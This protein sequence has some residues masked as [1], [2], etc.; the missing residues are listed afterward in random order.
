ME[1]AAGS[2][3]RLLLGLI[4]FLAV[5]L[6]AYHLDYY[7]L[8]GNE[9]F[10]LFL[11]ERPL[12]YL[13]TTSFR[14]E[15]NPPGFYSLLHGWIAIFGTSE[16][17]VRALSVVASLAVIPLV[18]ALGL[19]LFGAEAGLLGAL[20]MA[21]APMELSY[22][23]F[24]RT[25]ALLQIP[26][27]V[28]LLGLSRYLAHPESRR[29]LVGY[30]L[31]A[32]GAAYC[33]DTAILFLVSCNLV[34]VVAAGGP[35]ALISPR[36]LVHWFLTNALVAAILLPL[37]VV[38]RLQEHSANIGWIPPLH[39]SSVAAAITEVIAGTAVF[40]GYSHSLAAIESY[41]FLA[42]LA[43]ALWTAPPM[44]RRSRL[45]LLFLPAFFLGLV[46]LVS[47][48][49]PIFITRIFIWFW[50][51]LSLLLAH[52]FTCPTRVRYPLLVVT[53]W[54]LVFGVAA[55]VQSHYPF[56]MDW[57]EWIK[58]NRDEFARS[59]FIVLAPGSSSGPFIYYASNTAPLLRQWS[60]H[61]T[62][63]VAFEQQFEDEESPIS[64]LRTDELVSLIKSG[65]RGCLLFSG[66]ENKEVTRLL[67][68]VPP[69]A[70]RFQDKW[71][72]VYDYDL[73]SWGR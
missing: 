68:Q 34:V 7:S 35:S 61:P 16:N 10:A 52:A 66:S 2:R 25:Y 63:P 13:W 31:G 72:S 48:H 5:I 49:R 21:V 22:A 54:S 43:W 60:I 51:P 58:A 42:I 41:L 38:M 9:V 67:L 65:Q 4:L 18:Y 26:L 44:S 27:G 12:S 56:K 39:V 50:I 28:A 1:D 29:A 11:S 3:N 37:L 55:Q 47:L 53:A 32:A 62:T 57:R 6:R 64:P 23:Q 71:G 70:R 69:P 24:A 36:G 59:H 46:I 45:V 8:S 73:F 15:T 20:F 40:L 30:G 17:A 33:H 14:W 19:D